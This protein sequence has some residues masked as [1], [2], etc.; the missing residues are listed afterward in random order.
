MVYNIIGEVEGRDVLMIDDMIATAGT[1]C[2]AAK[3]I[4]ERGARSIRGA[5]THAVLAGPAV[6]R[7]ASA[8][9]NEVAVTDTIPVSAE[10]CWGPWWGSN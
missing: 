9:L 4:K 7:L 5:A 8:G 3:I 6:E 1:L 2:E 10:P